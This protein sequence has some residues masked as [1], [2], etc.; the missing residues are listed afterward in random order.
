MDLKIRLL[1]FASHLYFSIGFPIQVST[2]QS[3]EGEAFPESEEETIYSLILKSNEGSK[4]RLYEGD[5]TPKRHRNVMVCPFNWCFW[6]KSSNGLVI[7]P[8]VISSSYTPEEKALIVGAIQEY[9]ILT[10]IHFVARTTETD[11]IHISPKDGCWS[12]FGKVGGSQAVSVHKGG[13]MRKGI[14]QHEI[15][16]ALGM[17]HEQNRSDRDKYVVIAWQYISPGDFSHFKPTEA[18]TLGLEYDYASVMHYHRYAFS[19][20]SGKATITPVPDGTVPIGQRHGLSN[21]DVAKINKLYGCVVH[22]TLLSNLTG[23]F[24]STIYQSSSPNN[25]NPVWLIR[26]PANKIFLQFNSLYIQPSSDCASNHVLVYDG[27]SRSDI[28]LLNK[29]CR[30]KQLPS[31]VSSGNMMLVE[32][33][34]DGTTVP[35]FKASYSSVQCGNTFTAMNGKFESPLYPSRY[36]PLTD[37]AWIMMAPEGFKIS[38]KIQSFHLEDSFQCQH[39]YLVIYDGGTTAAPLKGKYCANDLVPGFISS[40]NSLLVEFHSDSIRQYSGFQTEYS[41]SKYGDSKECGV[42]TRNNDKESDTTLYE[43]D[44]LLRR[45]R[46]AMNCDNSCFWPKSHDGLVNI[47]INVSTEFSVEERTWIAEAMQEFTTLTCVQFIN[48]TT[49]TNYISVVPGESCWSHFGKIGGMQQVTLMKTGCM[50]KGAIQHELNH[51][52]GFLHEQARSDRDDHVKIQWE[53]IQAGEQ[54]NFGKINSNNLGLPYDYSS[55]MHYGTHD[56][57]NTSGKATIIPIPNPSV[58]IGQREGLSNLDVA[59]INKLYSCNCCSTVLHKP[60]GTFSSANYPSSYPDN[61]NCL[62]LIRVPQHKVFLQ[63]HTFDLQSSP[64]CT[65]DYIKIYDGSSK[66]SGTLLDKMCGMG[67]VPSL[68]ASR[69]AM[70]VEFVSDEATSAQGF[71]ASYNQAESRSA[72][73]NGKMWGWAWECVRGDRGGD[74]LLVSSPKFLNIQIFM[75]PSTA[76]SPSPLSPATYSKRCQYN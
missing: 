55:V 57:T 2:E 31:V 48:R 72:K 18:S 46:S 7:I 10:C 76:V 49:E 5:I 28:V 21:L 42:A 62:W 68:V 38:L 50:S 74:D 43:G 60:N 26:I 12:Y 17:L 58:V 27:G 37:C 35:T 34:S 41:F 53:Y 65:S 73:H 54:G 39:D 3:N 40:G 13:C 11:Y 71:Q 32:L 45:K 25:A 47:P 69:N 59:K 16:H 8:F 66:N 22:S 33:V 24:S 61:S 44:I 56:F 20:T 70:L 6:P 19:N 52:L 64:A 9:E 36:P 15:N 30:P 51:A 1:F 23:S 4:T 75:Q 29:L 14:I 67:P 63:F